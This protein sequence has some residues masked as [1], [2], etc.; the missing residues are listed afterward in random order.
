MYRPRLHEKFVSTLV[1]AQSDKQN[2]ILRLDLQLRGVSI[3]I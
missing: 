3:H 2:R 1:I